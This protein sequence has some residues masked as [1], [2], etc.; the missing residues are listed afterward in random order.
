MK[1][2]WQVKEAKVIAKITPSNSKK[3][4][5]TNSFKNKFLSLS[6]AGAE[7]VQARMTPM[8][9]AKMHMYVV[10]FMSQI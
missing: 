4:G 1:S 7:T 10:C 5:P 2:Q 3:S 9:T 8:K 6:I